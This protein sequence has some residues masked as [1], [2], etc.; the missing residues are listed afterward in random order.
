ML[1]TRQMHACSRMKLVPVSQSNQHNSLL[2]P[3]AAH[4]APW[5]AGTKLRNRSLGLELKVPAVLRIID[6]CTQSIKHH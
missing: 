1:W 5:G 2:R 6:A 3:R 4:S